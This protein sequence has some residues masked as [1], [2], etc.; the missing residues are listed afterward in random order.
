MRGRRPN[1]CGCALASLGV[2]RWLLCVGAFRVHFVWWMDNSPVRSRCITTTTTT[3][4]STTTHDEQWQHFCFEA[5]GRRISYLGSNTRD[6]TT[7][8]TAPQQQ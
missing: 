6:N 4:S 1:G 2:A 8:H 7:N 3:S 5:N